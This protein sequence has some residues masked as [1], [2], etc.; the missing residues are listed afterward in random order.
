MLHGLKVV[1][2]PFENFFILFKK[3]THTYTSLVQ[4]E[5]AELI[6]CNVAQSPDSLLTDVQHWRRQQGNKSRN[7]AVFHHLKQKALVGTPSAQVQ[8]HFRTQSTSHLLCVPGCS[9]SDV[10]QGPGCFKLQRRLV[11]HRQEGH[12]AGQQPGFDELLQR[13][14]SLLRQQLPER[15]HVTGWAISHLQF[16]G[17]NGFEQTL[18]LHSPGRL[19]ASGLGLSAVRGHLFNYGFNGQRRHLQDKSPRG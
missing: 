11:I 14:V 19:A 4:I 5:A 18:N 3:Y 12:K 7:G 16:S 17:Q 15:N 8:L 6:T 9:R 2:S 10:S 1:L 13:R